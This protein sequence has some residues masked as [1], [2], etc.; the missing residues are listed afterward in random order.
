E[1]SASDGIEYKKYNNTLSGFTGIDIYKF[2]INQKYRCFGYRKGEIF[3]VL[4][5]ET[6]HKLS[7]R[8]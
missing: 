3:Y 1:I 8:G 5:F 2:R 7:D 4:H 6:D